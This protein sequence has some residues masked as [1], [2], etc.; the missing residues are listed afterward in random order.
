MRI[1]LATIALLG[2]LQALLL[3][4]LLL[5]ATRAYTGIAR[6]SLRL[7]AAVLGLQAT[8]WV[9]ASLRGRISDWLSIVLA[10]GVLMVSYALTTHALRMLLHLPRRRRLL[11]AIGVLGWLGIT[12]F[13]VVMPDFRMR[14]YIAA[15]S[16]GG[17][18]ALLIW[19][20]RHALRRGG[21]TA[22]R[23]MLLVLGAASAVWCWRL[24]RM[25]LGVDPSSGLLDP[26]PINTAIMI[27]SAVE[28]V[29]A[30]IGFLLMY[31]EAVQAELHRLARTD[32]LTGTLNRLALD[33]EARRLFQ[34]AAEHDGGL[35]V[36][37]IDADHFK[38]INDRFGHAGGDRALT[39]L[40]T[41]IGR[42]LRASDVLG[43]A[44]GEEFL[45]LLP[46]AD[47][48]VTD[49]LA[50]RIRQQVAQLHPVLDGE[51]LTITVSI[52]VAA[53][54]SQDRHVDALIRRA[55]RALYAAKRA[56]RNRIAALP[57]IPAHE[58][59]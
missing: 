43:R 39:A 16:L 3:A 4:P 53:R 52:G 48:A 24:G 59:D 13:A 35:A 6:T 58:R 21:S 9:L 19:P 44:G 32:P 38:A 27:Y 17:Y 51:T 5:A 37:M 8:G 18:L 34:L 50:E 28:P 10:N 49:A 20:L 30:S 14:V 15:L 25:V 2:A 54:L 47:A 33:E 11:I 42:H 7:W 31:N 40:A 1:D 45:V 55:D 56:G 22:Q 23:V 26:T 57:A 46:E 41:C 36:L 12:W 29:L